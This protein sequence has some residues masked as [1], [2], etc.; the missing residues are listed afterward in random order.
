MQTINRTLQI[1]SIQHEL[2]M[3]IGL[4]LQLESMLNAFMQRALNR[5]SLRAVVMYVF[6]QNGNP[7]DTLSGT[8]EHSFYCYP[9][10]ENKMQNWLADQ[11]TQF[12][13]LQQ[14]TYLHIEQESHQ[15]Y[16][17][18]VPK[19]GVLILQRMHQPIDEMVMAALLPLLSKLS[20][21]CRACQEHQNLIEEIEARKNA[22]S[23]LIRQSL[24][25]SLTGLSNRKRFNID[26]VKALSNNK[27]SRMLGAIFIIDLD[28]FKVIN[29]SL[30]HG[31][32]DE[33]LKVIGHRLLKYLSEGE[34]LAR[35]GGDEFVLLVTRLSTQR[36]SAM[37]RAQKI[38]EELSAIIAEPVQVE[39]NLINISSSTG[40]NL[41]PAEYDGELT[42]E[43]Q[44][45]LLVKNANLALYKVKHTNRNGF[46]FFSKELQSLS[47]RKTK[48]EK[49][50]R[51]AVVSNE[52][53]VYYQPLVTKDG[54]ILGGEALL[55]WSNADLGH[56]SPAD[57]IPI[58]EE[59]GLILEIGSW[60]IEQV[61]A[62]IHLME[63][64]KQVNTPKYISVNVSPRQF[65]HHNFA[66][67]LISILSK[68]NVDSKRI[69]IEI[70][71]GVAI[72][73]IDL[74]VQKI[75]RLKDHG[76]V[77][78]LDDFGS[79]YSSLS[80]LHQ[81]PL[82]TIKI[83][84][85]FI[86]NI[87]TSKNHRVIVDSIIDICEHFSLECIVEGVETRGEF[88]YLATKNITSFQGYY[89]HRPMPKAQFLTLLN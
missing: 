41:F 30:G 82:Q 28:R 24:L 83:D 80:Y 42:T 77:C 20:A 26:L 25:D 31:I 27:N 9:K 65:T 57:F 54:Q 4:D 52:F 23:L 45:D 85:S 68:Y 7:V 72:D 60:V 48:I 5:L 22:E 21:S 76:V 89:F 14:D 36:T 59:S 29:D 67:R 34:T 66:D 12:F 74:T 78:M 51:T 71:E 84:R 56:I 70:T 43:Q 44:R 32:G 46:C 3:N 39:E 69:R 16:F 63:V 13:A 53:E 88:D 47:E 38:A 18:H 58:A 35:T 6:N 37:S 2:A 11:A 62:F 64:S 17:L 73:N 86:S 40:I 75:Q 50:L 19:F 10:T 61:C 1:I 81:L 87:D 55:R 49:Q 33:V 15:Y 79:G 8:E